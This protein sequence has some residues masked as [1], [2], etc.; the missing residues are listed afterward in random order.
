MQVNFEKNLVQKYI[1]YLVPDVRNVA[2]AKEEVSFYFDARFN[3]YP[4]VLIFRTESDDKG[5]RVKYEYDD[6]A[7]PGE[8]MTTGNYFPHRQGYTLKVFVEKQ[9]EMIRL[10]DAM[11]IRYQKNPYVKLLGY[12]L[13]YPEMQIGLW[14]TRLEVEDIRSSYD[15]KGAQRVISFDFEVNLVISDVEIVPE[16]EEYRIGGLDI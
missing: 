13:D 6:N 10:R 4:S 15:E 5:F 3:A 1:P 16:I 14:L 8:P 12:S 9:S 2:F 11:R 7:S